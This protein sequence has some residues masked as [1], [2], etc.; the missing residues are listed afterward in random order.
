M[1][2]YIYARVS[3]FE[4]FH[5]GFSI[6]NQCTSGLTYAKNNLLLPGLATNCGL[7]GVFIDGG[8]SAYTKKLSQRPGGQALMAVLKPGDT[9]I[10]TATHRLFRKMSDMVTTMEY[11]VDNGISVVFTDYPML[12]T[13]T[14]NGRA[15][16]RIFAVVAELKSDLTSARVRE[17]RMLSKDKPKEPK[18]APVVHA[19][20]ENPT[21][22]DIGSVMQAIAAD[23][24]RS[25]F[26]FTG[27]V[28]AYI[29]CSTKDQTVEQQRL[30]I[31]KQLPQDMKESEIVWYE[32]EGASAFKT[33]LSKRKAGA[34]MLDDLKAGDIVVAWRPDR[35]FRSMLDMARMTEA[36]HAKGSYLMTVEGG[37][38]TDTP[39]GKTVVSLLSLLAEV[40]S[41]EISR[42][43][44]QGLMVALGVNPAA[45]AARA[46]KMLGE[47]K[48]RA[49]QKHFC[50]NQFFSK[51]ERFSMHIH[52]VLTAK[53][54]RDRRTACRVISNQWLKRKGFPSLTGETGDT[55]AM[56]QAKVKK[57]Q[58]VEFSEKRDRL[59]DVLKKYGKGT[60]VMYPLNV[61][62]IAH[63]FPRMEE[64]IRVA[65]PIRGRLHDKKGLTAMAATCR[66]PEEAVRLME[67]L[68]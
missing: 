44:K 24:E 37:I 68:R 53:Q 18:A 61:D 10:A 31:L 60:L 15:M 29:R 52:L 33:S 34:K 17:A 65:K 35:I 59:L 56:Y 36:I 28:R 22:K 1:S 16:L 38:K 21:S 49:G 62:T 43:T 50:F 4:Q 9:V 30:C 40:E 39:F 23:R 3:T 48:D 13:N 45:Q 41:Q 46:P 55:L 12:S 63:V 42:S 47:C 51:A 8:K 5:S 7:T 25:K 6:D 57:M 66:N 54:Y 26:R 2:A 27:K 20:I 32:D 19:P 58:A 11:W 64:W 14:A 67:V